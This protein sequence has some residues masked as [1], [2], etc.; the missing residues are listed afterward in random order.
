M[1]V[2]CFSTLRNTSRFVLPLLVL[3]AAGTRAQAP[4][5][6]VDTNF[7]ATQHFVPGAPVQSAI[8]FTGSLDT[9]V[10]KTGQKALSRP[11]NDFIG[12]VPINGRSD[13]G[14]VI[15]NHEQNTANAVLGHGGGMSVFTAHRKNNVW[16]VA[17]HPGGRFR[18]VDFTPVG[19]TL[20]NCGGAVTP[21]GTV[22]T[23]EEAFQTSN[24]GLRNNGNGFPDTTDVVVPVFNGQTVNRTLKRYQA[25][26]WIVEVDAASATALKKHYNMG[27]FSHEMGYSM[28]D[29][30]TVYLADDATPAVFFKFVSDTVGN[31]NKGQLYAYKQSADGNSGSWIALPMDLDSMMS[32]RA[33]AFRRGATTFTRHEWITQVDGKVYITE[34]GNDNPGTSHRSAVRTGATLPRHLATPARMN[35]DSSLTPDYFGRILRFDPATDKLDVYLEGGPASAGSPIHLANPDGLTSVTLNGKS[36]LVIQENLNGTSQGRVSAAANTAGRDIPELY[37]LEVTN[38][39]SRDSLKRMMVGPAECELTGG[40]F[41]PDGATFFINVQHPSSSNPA[42]YNRAYT[43][44]IWGYHTPTGLVFDAPAFPRSKRVQ[45]KV[46]AASG[47]AYFDRLTDVDLFNTAGRRLERHKGV[48]MLDVQHLGPGNYLLRFQGGESLPLVLP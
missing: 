19:G 2:P 40:R 45:V 10:T 27:R 18:Q 7:R 38:T 30:K 36:Y 31:Y 48:R 28:P 22:T 14:Y 17:D 33:L 4:F 41:T 43:L 15:Q 12:Y 3:A 47:F 8:L 24:S 35:T 5:T 21:W 9:V 20:G 1:P 11:E 16:S 42:P 34:T 37:W 25:M 29:G 44:A 6:P 26:N 39:P 23:G 32:I 46:N 13:S